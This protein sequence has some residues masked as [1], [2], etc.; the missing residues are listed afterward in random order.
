[1]LGAGMVGVGIYNIVE[2]R[3]FENFAQDVYVTG[4]VLFVLVGVAKIIISI[5]GII[6]WGTGWRILLAIVSGTPLESN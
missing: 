1:M 5:L 6:G 3:R 4:G 2:I